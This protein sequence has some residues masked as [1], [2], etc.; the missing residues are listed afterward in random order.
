MQV[1]ISRDGVWRVEIR[2]AVCT[3]YEGGALV[4]DR[5]SLDR[6]VAHLVEHGVDPVRNL[7][8]D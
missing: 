4:L 1:L 2:A 3:L 6:V 5:V 8:A 7:V